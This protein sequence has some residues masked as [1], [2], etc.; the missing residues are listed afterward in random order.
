[1]CIRDS[2]ICL[3]IFFTNFK[4]FFLRA[5]SFLF[6]IDLLGFRASIGLPM[7]ASFLF[8]VYFWNMQMAVFLSLKIMKTE[9]KKPETTRKKQQFPFR[10]NDNAIKIQVFL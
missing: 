7:Q 3:Y 6:V 4:K 9:W 2:S 5:S 10:I 1:M 8:S